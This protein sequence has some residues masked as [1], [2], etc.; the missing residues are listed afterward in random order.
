MKEIT[1]K[2]AL[3]AL[4]AL[5]HVRVV[6]AQVELKSSPVLLLFEVFNFSVEKPLSEDWGIEG[7]IWVVFDEGLYGS[8]NGK[9]YLNPLRGA[10]GIHVGGFLGASP[11][12]GVGIGFLGGYK[13]VSSKNFLFEAG[14]GIGRAI[15]YDAEG[16][17]PYG[18]LHIGL[19]IAEKNSK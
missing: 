13:W 17:I 18:K 11:D 1:C 12:L 3:F 2:L 10:D 7:D 8:F 9:Y 6:H 16:V 14:L 19:R 4:F 15:G 5:M